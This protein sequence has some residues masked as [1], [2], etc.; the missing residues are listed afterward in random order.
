MTPAKVQEM[1]LRLQVI[2]VSLRCSLGEVLGRLSASELQEAGHL[3][4]CHVNIVQLVDYV[5]YKAYQD[6]L[7]YLLENEDRINYISNFINQIRESGNTLV[8]VD[9]VTPGKRLT[10]LVPDAVFVSGATKA[11]ERKEEYDEIGF[12]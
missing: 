11:D 10:E 8:L 12:G 9:R 1:S 2:F 4:N 3:A 7:R 6:E 5:E